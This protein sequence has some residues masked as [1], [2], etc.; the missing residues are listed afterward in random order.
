MKRNTTIVLLVLTL[1]LVQLACNLPGQDYPTDG[2]SATETFISNIGTATVTLPPIITATSNPNQNQNATNTP[3][4]TN[5]PQPTATKSSG[6]GTSGTGAC[7]NRATFVQDLTIPDDSV[8]AAGSTFVK[9]WL[10]RNDGTCTWGPSGYPLHALVFTGGSQM[11]ASSPLPLHTNVPP[12]QTVDV[13]VPLTAPSNPGTYY[14][15]WMFLVNNSTYVGV[16]PN[17]DQPLYTR[18]K[19]N[20]SLTRLN[21]ASGATATSV[22]GSLG[23]NQSKGYVLAAM[24]NQV[25]MAQAASA[26]EGLKIKITASDNTSLGGSSNQGGTSAMAALPSTQDYIVWVSTGSQ[27]ANYTLAITIPSRITFDPG[28]TSA[29]VDGKV[30]NHFQVSYILRASGGQTMTAKLTGS[31]VGLTIYGLTDGQPL[32]RAEGGATSWTGTLPATQDYII[33]AVPAVDST[34]FTLDVTVK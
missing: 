9:T 32:V 33:I 22:T 1:V 31:N 28:A 2:M 10:V 4:P 23:A 29:S 15:D 27:S 26:A 34:T 21:F 18:I 20:S 12:G 17:G 11:G 13:S 24:K 19:V 8:V 25:I 6:G 5:S 30:S 7:T 3:A 14:S 16:G